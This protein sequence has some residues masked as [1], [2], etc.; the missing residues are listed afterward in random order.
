[1]RNQQCQ[2]SYIMHTNNHF[3]AMSTCVSQHPQVMTGAELYCPLTLAD[4]NLHIWIR[5]KLLE[6]SSVLL[7]IPSLHHEQLHCTSSNIHFHC[8][9]ESFCQ[10]IHSFV[11]LLCYVVREPVLLTSLLAT[12]RTKLLLSCLQLSELMLRS[13]TCWIR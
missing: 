10:L 11:F 7:C 3:M 5:K 12:N 4:G 2:N 6:F 9:H 1:M 8:H 13:Y